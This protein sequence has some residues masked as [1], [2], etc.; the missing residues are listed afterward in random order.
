MSYDAYRLY[1][2]E[3]VKGPG[4]VLWADEQAA[5]LVSAVSSLFRGMA[6]PVRAA[7]K[8]HVIAARGVPARHDRLAYRLGCMRVV[9]RNPHGPR[10]S[11]RVGRVPG[12][13][14]SAD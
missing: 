5:R 2:I 4:E 12:R 8:H 3:R 11:R 7:R 14:E 10:V 6:R 9:R 13:A 1:Q